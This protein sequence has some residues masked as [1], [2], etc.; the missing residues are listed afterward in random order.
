VAVAGSATWF[1]L[2]ALI[3]C[4]IPSAAGVTEAM[5]ASEFPPATLITVWKVTG[6]P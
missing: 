2:A 5:C 1:R 3:A 6:I 4:V